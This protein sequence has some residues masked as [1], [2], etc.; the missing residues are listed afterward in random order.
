M[1]GVKVSYIVIKEQALQALT[2]LD[3][4]TRD[5]TPVM[6]DFAQYMLRSVDQ[7]FDAQG[8]PARWAPLKVSTMASWIESRKSWKTKTGTFNKKGRDALGGRRILTDSGLL[9][10]SIHFKALARGVEGYTDKKYAAIQHF[11]GT[12]AAH[13]IKPRYKKALFWPGAGHPVKS[14]QH[15]GSRIPARPFLMF[16]DAD[17]YGYLYPRLEVYLAGK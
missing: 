4:R 17:V 2:G 12:T 16:Q 14:V 8:R 9:R 11:G 10:N 7:N 15:P 5:L 6:Q 13:T 1:A 3:L